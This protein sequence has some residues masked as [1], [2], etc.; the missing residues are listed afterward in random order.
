MTHFSGSGSDISE[1]ARPQRTF[2]DYGEERLRALLAAAAPAS[3]RR[4]LLDAFQSMIRPW[5][6]QRL[7]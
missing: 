6:N 1:P 7:G 2:A 4:L 5:A 3:E